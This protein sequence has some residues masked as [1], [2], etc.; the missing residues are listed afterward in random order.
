MAASRTSNRV[1][2]P[3]VMQRTRKV[4]RMATASKSS[5]EAA[6]TIVVSTANWYTPPG[7]VGGK[8]DAVRRARG[9]SVG[10]DADGS[11]GNGDDCGDRDGGR[12]CVGRNDGGGDG[13][14]RDDGGSTDDV[15]G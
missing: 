10:G 13:G 7:G 9:G 11:G 15:D 12:D 2:V 5:G 4:A 3:A 1:R 6:T 8:S 14:G